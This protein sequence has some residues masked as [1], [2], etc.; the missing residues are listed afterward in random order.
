M[1][2]ARINTAE[3]KKDAQRIFQP[4]KTVFGDLREVW[5]GFDSRLSEML[6]KNFKKASGWAGLAEST[7]KTRERARRLGQDKRKLW[8]RSRGVF[9]MAGCYYRRTRPL[10]EAGASGPIG[11]WTGKSR[12][13]TKVKGKANRTTYEKTFGKKGE[14]RDRLGYLHHGGPNRP[15]RPLFK[16]K[17]VETKCKRYFNKAFND[18]VKAFDRGQLDPELKNLGRILRD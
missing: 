5:R 1:I 4:W 10:K 9:R 3:I 2:D 18:M 17:R 8:S 16:R 6:F 15:P 13:R 12:N 7:K 14:I 11:V